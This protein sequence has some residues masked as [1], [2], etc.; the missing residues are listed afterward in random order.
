MPS[1]STQEN[2]GSRRALDALHAHSDA[3]E[4]LREKLRD[5]YDAGLDDVPTARMERENPERYDLGGQS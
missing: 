1:I 3:A 2:A 4:A 5:E